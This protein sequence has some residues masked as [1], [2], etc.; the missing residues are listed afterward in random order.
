MD[1]RSQ[2]EVGAIS[3]MLTD[4]E[5]EIT[6][7]SSCKHFSHTSHSLPTVI[8]S[9]D[10]AELAPLTQKEC[11]ARRGRLVQVLGVRGAQN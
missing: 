4:H 8:L 3:S 7:Q 2:A 10:P 5:L 11:L 6:G 1:T 9:A